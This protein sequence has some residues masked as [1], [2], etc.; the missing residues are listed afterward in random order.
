MTVTWRIV[1]RVTGGA[2]LA[3]GLLWLIGDLHLAGEPMS[4][5]ASALGERWHSWHAPSLNLLQAIVERYV[6]PQLWTYVLLPLLLAPAWM[7]AAVF[8]TVII[9]L[10][11]KPEREVSC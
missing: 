7:V 11:L 3:L 4:Y 6:L 2:V 1:A 5:R 8:G 9:A 10:G